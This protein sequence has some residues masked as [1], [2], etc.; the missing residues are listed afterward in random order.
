MQS[1][2]KPCSLHRRHEPTFGHF[3]GLSG[4]PDQ[5]NQ[6][7][8]SI[9]LQLDVSG[10][11]IG[12]LHGLRPRVLQTTSSTQHWF[13]A[14]CEKACSGLGQACVASQSSSAAQGHA[15][16]GEHHTAAFPHQCPPAVTSS[17]RI[18]VLWSPLSHMHQGC[19][20]TLSELRWGSPT[21]KPYTKIAA[22]CPGGHAGWTG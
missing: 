14:W 13:S 3:A 15:L 2:G 18:P 17:R 5:R 11:A 22:A 1:S 16:P 20:V 12:V 4:L 10:R 19:T 8:R 6:P 21:P 9:N 7:Q